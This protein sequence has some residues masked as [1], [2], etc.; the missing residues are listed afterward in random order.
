MGTRFTYITSRGTSVKSG[1]PF[2]LACCDCGLVH[3]VVLVSEDEKPVGV[4]MKRDN[5]ATRKRRSAAAWVKRAEK[6]IK[7]YAKRS[8]ANKKTARE[9]LISLG[10]YTKSGKLSKR[11]GG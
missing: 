4:A 11:Y 10:I 6:Q 8:T 5:A 2:L 3:K 7:D 9:V 1:S